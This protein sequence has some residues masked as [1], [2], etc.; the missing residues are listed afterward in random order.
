[1]CGVFGCEST[2]PSTWRMKNKTHNNVHVEWKSPCWSKLKQYALLVRF[3]NANISLAV[4][5]RRSLH[6]GQNRACKQRANGWRRRITHL[7]RTMHNTVF[8]R[9]FHSWIPR[10]DLSTDAMVSCNECHRTQYLN[11][12]FEQ[13]AEVCCGFHIKFASC[14]HRQCQMLLCQC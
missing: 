11:S 7:H 4:C 10:D 1:M 14:S 2:R 6:C 12:T 9:R 13:N 8:N 5:E 3:S